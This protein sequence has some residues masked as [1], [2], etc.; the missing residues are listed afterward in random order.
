M[1]LKSFSFKTKDGFEHWINRWIPDSDV[2]I[3]GIIQL[4]HGLSEHSLRYDRFGS[5]LADNG[6]VLNAFDMRGHGKTGEISQQNGSGLMGKLAD[7]KGHEIVIEDLHEIT[8]AVKNEYPGVPVV[9]MG[10]SFGSF[11]TQGFIE[12]YGDTVNACILSGTAGP[13]KAMIGASKVIVKIIKT[14]TGNDKF[15]KF[16]ETLA[17]GSYN[18]GIE[19]A[20]KYDW[21]SRDKLSVQMYE[22]DNWCGIP[23][24]ASFY[25][26]MTSLLS[27]IHK[28]SNIKKINKQLPILFIYGTKDPVGSYGKTIEKLISIYKKNDINKLSVIKYE[29]ARH[30][31]LNEINKEEVETDLINWISNTLTESKK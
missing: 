19:N 27:I 30:E 26:D 29:G 23:L 17:F 9:V 3:K 2:E 16:L 24:V 1:Q 4:H 22:M 18:K 31:P 12:K 10:H 8:E 28:T 5:I 15:V 25:Y 21:L 14:F 7:K 20:G 11:V 6:Y 13:R